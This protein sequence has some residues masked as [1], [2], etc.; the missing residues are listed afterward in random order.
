L[1]EF[2]K[3]DPDEYASWGSPEKYDKLKFRVISIE[4]NQLTVEIIPKHYRNIPIEDSSE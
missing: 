4:N 3:L 2:K 1:K